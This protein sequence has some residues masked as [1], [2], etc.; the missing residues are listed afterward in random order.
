MVHSMHGIGLLLFPGF[1]SRRVLH[2]QETDPWFWVGARVA[3]PASRVS[4]SCRGR[5]Q[6][7]STVAE[8]P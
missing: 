5:R 1:I 8:R 7:E 3:R 4:A 6:G 2:S